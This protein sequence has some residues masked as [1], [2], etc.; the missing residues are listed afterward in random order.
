MIKITHAPRR[1]CCFPALLGVSYPKE[2]QARIV[3]GRPVGALA[4]GDIPPNTRLAD[5]C[6]TAKEKAPL[7]GADLSARAPDVLLNSTRV[8]L[9]L[10]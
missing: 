1:S 3:F 8:A 7:S 10:P 5:A 9:R 4:G 2:G 6:L